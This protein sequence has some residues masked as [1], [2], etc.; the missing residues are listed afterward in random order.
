MEEKKSPIFRF[1]LRKPERRDADMKKDVPRKKKKKIPANKM[2]GSEGGGPTKRPGPRIDLKKSGFQSVLSSRRRGERLSLTNS[3]DA[4]HP[5]SLAKSGSEKEQ[6]NLIGPPPL[7]RG[8]RS[9]EKQISK[10]KTTNKKG[11]KR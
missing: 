8:G 9:F 4:L 1:V 7:K 3:R 2:E 10:E 11:E 5:E 6:T